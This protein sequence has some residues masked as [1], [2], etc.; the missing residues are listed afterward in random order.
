MVLSTTL[1][2]THLSHA[3][4]QYG[5]VRMWGTVGWMVAGWVLGLWLGGSLA[6]A[7]LTAWPGA[8][9][10]DQPGP[11]LA[12]MFR[13]AGLLSLVLA[14]YALTL[15]HTPPARHPGL[16]WAPLVAL[17]LLLNRDF[18]VYALGSFVVSLS[19]GLNSQAAPLLLEDLGVAKGWQ[20]YALTVA[21]GTE[22][23]TLALLPALLHRLGM[24]ST[25]LLGLA[26]WTATLAVFAVG[27][28]AGL[29]I[30]SLA[31]WGV[32][33]CCYLI[34]GQV[35]VNRLARGPIRASAQSLLSA[36]NAAGSFV[37]SLLAGALRNA[38]AGAVGPVYTVAVNLAVVIVLL[39][40][41]RFGRND[42]AHKA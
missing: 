33:V 35:L 42:L 3:E 7:W 10:P 37:G 1:A 2:F 11:A 39:F 9:R 32:C 29:V 38:S 26:C 20:P 13:L 8:V 18:A 28:P 17:G 31:G 16:G 41:F 30:A 22:V 27:R 23:L 19:M 12:D 40:Y 14:V 24:R 6:P 34:A 5:P 36:G 25:M 15:P 4:R 21:Q